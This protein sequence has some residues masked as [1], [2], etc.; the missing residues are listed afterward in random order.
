[1]ASP[2]V[3]DYSPNRCISHPRRPQRVNTA[4]RWAATIRRRSRAHIVS[5]RVCA[6]VSDRESG[7]RSGARARPDFSW[8][9]EGRPCPRSNRE[10]VDG[11]LRSSCPRAGID[12]GAGRHVAQRPADIRPVEAGRRPRYRHACP[13]KGVPPVD[14]RGHDT[15][16]AAAHDTGSGL[17][18]FPGRR[19]LYRAA[20]SAVPPDPRAADAPPGARAAAAVP[21]AAAAA[22]QAP[23]AARSMQRRAAAAISPAAR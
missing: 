16:G 7:G 22:A 5:W 2:G 17:G 1:M 6:L 8:A 10:A 12:H 3:A 23:G 18:Q 15:T 21:V 14:G 11:P 20:E 19:G 13:R 4:S 9:R